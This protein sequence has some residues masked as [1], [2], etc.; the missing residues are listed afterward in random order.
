MKHILMAS[1]AL[2]VL[3]PTAAFAQS[4]FDG[5]WKADVS[6]AK[7]PEKPSEY[8]L[9]DG[10]YSCKTCVPSYS[11]K[12]DG[13]DHP[14]S[15]NKYVDSV[16]LKIVDD[17]TTQETDKRGGK[18]VATSTQTASADG[19]SLTIAFS[20]ASNSNGAPVTGKANAVR[21]GKMV[22]GEH[23]TSGM[24]RTTSYSDISDNGIS[25]T[26]KTNGDMLTMTA[27]TGQS[28]TAKTDGSEAPMK[29]DPGITSV[30]V[31]MMGKNML[32]ET[33][34]RGAKVVGVSKM[35]LEPDGKTIDIVYQ[36]KLH[37]TS[38]SYKAAKQ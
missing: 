17:H 13:M 7:P 37:G 19:N 27:P 24:W 5:T 23:A 3:A 4:G 36:D 16:A 9:K 15:G 6:S 20:D 25:V 35:T 33:D 32:E 18:V 8:R 31:K 1:L 2:A 38:M 29:G 26:Y 34:K 28:Y 21:V 22:A 14:I 12:A 10:M 30:S 11:I